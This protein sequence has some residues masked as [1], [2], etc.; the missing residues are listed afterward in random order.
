MVIVV[1]PNQHTITPE[2]PAALRQSRLAGNAARSDHAATE[3]ADPIWS[4]VDPRSDSGCERNGALLDHKYED[5]WNALGALIAYSAA[6]K[7]AKKLVPAL[8]PLALSDYAISQGYRAWNIP[9][10]GEADPV[11]SLK[12]GSRI[13]DRRVLEEKVLLRPIVDTTTSL[14]T[15]PTALVYGDSFVEVMRRF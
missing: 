9:P 5:H 8:Q 7:E 15:A 6:M 3:D 4:V 12:S 1:A 13:V 11:F 14:N 2:Y 10:L